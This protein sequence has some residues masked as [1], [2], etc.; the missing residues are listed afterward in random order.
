MVKMLKAKDKR[1]ERPTA[2][3]SRTQATNKFT[4][5]LPSYHTFLLDI[6]KYKLDWRKLA[7]STQNTTINDK[8]DVWTYILFLPFNIWKCMKVI[9]QYMIC[10]K[11]R[12]WKCHILMKFIWHYKPLVYGVHC[13]KQYNF[14][15]WHYENFRYSRYEK[16][17]SFKQFI[18]CFTVVYQLGSSR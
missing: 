5:V 9:K 3:S 11:S 17:N 14:S 6:I 18:Q 13:V 12:P 2:F 4:Y 7:R 1:L 15:M 10:L 16:G 8:L